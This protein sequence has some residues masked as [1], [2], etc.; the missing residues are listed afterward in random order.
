MPV[1]GA[2][3]FMSRIQLNPRTAFWGLFGPQTIFTVDIFVICL[4]LAGKLGLNRL[5]LD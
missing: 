5:K 4:I 1:I 2:I 3:T